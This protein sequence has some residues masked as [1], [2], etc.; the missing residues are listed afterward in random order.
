MIRGYGMAR[1]RA[2][3]KYEMGTV[4][5]AA[6]MIWASGSRRSGLYVSRG[7]S[8]QMIGDRFEPPD[9]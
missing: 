9:G 6:S 8:V 5:K 1:I 4:R 2:T 7:I 3:R